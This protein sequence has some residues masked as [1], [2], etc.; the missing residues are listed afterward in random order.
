MGC[1]GFS[2]N[3]LSTQLTSCTTNFPN[4]PL[5]AHG[6]ISLNS[7]SAKVLFSYKLSE[8]SY[9]SLVPLLL[10]LNSYCSKILCLER[11]LG[12][13][14][15]S[16]I[17]F[18]FIVLCLSKE[19]LQSIPLSCHLVCVY[20][21]SFRTYWITIFLMSVPKINKCIHNVCSGSAKMHST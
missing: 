18:L 17:L 20:I 4:L 1:S 21:K 12:L 3:F 19:G 9:K 6:Q 5:M 15:G 7:L 2:P 11:S 10:K 13:N 14:L 16:I 8:V